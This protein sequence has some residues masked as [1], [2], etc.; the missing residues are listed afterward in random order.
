[1][2]RL[3]N[4]VAASRSRS[5]IAMSVQPAFAIVETIASV[6]TLC[7]ALNALLFLSKIY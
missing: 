6:E 4:V 2:D 3:A 7:A 5:F 1:M